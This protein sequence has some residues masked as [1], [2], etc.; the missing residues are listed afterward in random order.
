MSKSSRQLAFEALMRV[1]NE[2]AYSNITLNIVLS[3]NKSDMRDK[4]FTSV[5]FY[6]VLEK[7]LLL[8]YNLSR[9]SEKPVNKL[10]KEMLV[11]LRMGLYQL[12]FMDSVP[13]SAAVNESVKLCKENN[14]YNASGYANGV[15]RC[16]SRSDG[17]SLPNRR[18]GKNKYLSIKYSCPENIIKL[19]RDSY[20]DDIT[21][22]ILS[23]LEGRPPIAARV[24]T[25]KTDSNKLILS[26]R[27]RHIRSEASGIIDDCIMLKETGSIE[28]IGQYS[29]GLFHVQDSASQLCCRLLSAKPGNTVI[30][31]CSAPGGKAFTIAQHMGNIGNIIS[32]DMYENRL[33]LVR[34]GAERLGIDIIR[35][36]AADSSTY[37]DFPIAD[38]VLCDVPCSGLG[39]IRRKP[40]L[41]YKNDLG[42]DSLPD[43]QYLILCNCACFVKRGGILI[44][45]TCTLNPAEN[46]MNIRKFLKEHDEFEPYTLAV[47]AGIARGIDE[48]DNEL[49]LFPHIN[50]TDGF[51]IGAVK[52]K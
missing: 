41:R 17:L 39:I 25:L 35:T 38:R 52:R 11:I 19:W 24:N 27:G 22:G 8:D 49:T 1:E 3:E 5:L 10:D 28:N 42:L 18:K 50:G 9:F 6:G 13:P 51:F 46:G 40:E 14:L 31:A 15:L 16:A 20:G 29:E 26:L 34:Q 33:R 7:K 23:S 44:Y 32:C 45:S 12:F 21:E 48:P 4:A 36:V 43:L 47:P 30:D 37:N 2:Q